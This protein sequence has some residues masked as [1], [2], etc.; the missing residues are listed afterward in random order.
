MPFYY[1]DCDEDRNRALCAQF[2]VQGFPTLKAFPRGG[3]G[4]ARDY[5]GARTR[6]ALV[7]YAKSLV[8]ERVSK[9]RLDSKGDGAALV[10]KF[11]KDKKDLPHALLVHASQPSIPFLWKVLGHRLSGKVSVPG[12]S[13]QWRRRGLKLHRLSSDT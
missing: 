3:K 6:S 4:S 11:R 7:E 1:V 13:S 5:S 9:L 10:K 2:G 12:G 8:P